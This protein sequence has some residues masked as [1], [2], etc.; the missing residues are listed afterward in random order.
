MRLSCM[1]L[2]FIQYATVY[3]YS[4][5]IMCGYIECSL[6]LQIIAFMV[7]FATSHTSCVRVSLY[8]ERIR[9]NGGEKSV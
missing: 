5:K 2:C 8:Q 9:K 4:G 1:Y 3:Y 7:L 6:S